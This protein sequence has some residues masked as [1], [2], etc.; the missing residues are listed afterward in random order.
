M[1]EEFKVYKEKPYTNSNGE[2]FGVILNGRANNYIQA[3]HK[4]RDLIKKGV[5]LDVDYKI[6]PNQHLKRGKLKLL[7]VIATKSMMQLYK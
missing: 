7:N 6:E 4:F 5:E 3:H 1:T 2:P